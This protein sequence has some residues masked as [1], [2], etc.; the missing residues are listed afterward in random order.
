MPW[1][2]MRQHENSAGRLSKAT[3][4]NLHFQDTRL[5]GDDRTDQL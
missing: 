3:Q 5:L 1:H 2:L 4:E